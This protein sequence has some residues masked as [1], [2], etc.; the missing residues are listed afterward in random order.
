MGVGGVAG[1]MYNG[2]IA[3]SYNL[4]T[5]NTMRNK[6]SFTIG[7][8]Y[9]V[10]MGGVVGDTTEQTEAGALLYDV[11][12]K[13]QIGDET[14]TYYARHVGGVVGRLSVPWKKPTIP[15]RSI[16]ATV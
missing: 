8:Y 15:V 12:N 2:E 7:D 16:T 6:V 14:F 1:M 10:N 11:Y 5:V 4:G 13:G 9:A 3:G